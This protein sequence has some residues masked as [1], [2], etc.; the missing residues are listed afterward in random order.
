[1]RSA[2]DVRSSGSTQ[3]EDEPSLTFAGESLSW[4]RRSS[5]KWPLRVEGTARPGRVYGKRNTKPV[6]KPK[7]LAAGIY[8]V[9]NR[10]MELLIVVTEP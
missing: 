8:G 3:V 5:V 6:L 1:M 10:K 7:T 4:C 9:P 2:P